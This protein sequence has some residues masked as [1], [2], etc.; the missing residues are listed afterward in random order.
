M[1]RFHIKSLFILMKN[2]VTMELIFHPNLECLLTVA[3]TPL[4]EY[5]SMV[6]AKLALG[7]DFC[8]QTR[9]LKI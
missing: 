3:E 6:D 8:L 5:L 1:K 4:L 2:S 7:K 9:K